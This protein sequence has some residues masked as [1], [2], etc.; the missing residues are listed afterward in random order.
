MRLTRARRQFAHC[1]GA[2]ARAKAPIEERARG[3]AVAV[4]A[5]VARTVKWSALKGVA[6]VVAA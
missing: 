1:C 5:N 6:A 4:V 2:R 3:R